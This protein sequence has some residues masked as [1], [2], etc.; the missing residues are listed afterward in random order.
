VFQNKTIAEHLETLSHCT[1][2]KDG[3]IKPLITDDERRELLG[4]IDKV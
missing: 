2:E 1:Y 3:K 4:V